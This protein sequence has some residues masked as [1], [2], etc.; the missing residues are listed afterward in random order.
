MKRYILLSLAIAILCAI[1]S[2]A[3]ITSPYPSFS[4]PSY[5]DPDYRVPGYAEVWYGRKTTLGMILDHCDHRQSVQDSSSDQQFRELSA[6]KEPDAYLAYQRGAKLFNERDYAQALEV[7][8]QLK[9]AP[10]PERGWWEKFFDRKSHSWVKEAS[11]YMVARCQLVMAQKNWSGYRGS[12]RLI[13]RNMV[14]SA[15]SSYRQYLDEYPDGIYANSARNIFR[16]IYVLLGK[17]MYLDQALREAVLEQY[18]ISTNYSPDKPVNKDIIQE[19][20]RYFRGKV[21]F[22]HDSPILCAYAW[23]GPD[24]PDPGDMTELEG[25]KKDFVVY[26]GLFRYVRALGLY[27]L[28]RYRE[29]LDKTPDEPIADTVMW[30]S[31]QILRARAFARLGDET[32][33][34]NLLEK[35]LD[36]SHE[37]EVE[38]EIADQ[39]LNR[40]DGLWLFTD[41]SPIESERNLR[42]FALYGLTDKELEFGI[43]MSEIDGK[44]QRFLA[45]ELARRYIL[46]GRFKELARLFAKDLV[47]VFFPIKLAAESLAANPR[48]VE[49]LADVGEFLYEKDINP[50][51]LLG[52]FGN[53]H[54]TGDPREDL[55]RCK[56]CQDFGERTKSYTP[57]ISFF[58]SVVEISKSTNMKSEAEAKALHYIVLGGKHGKSE[59]RCTWKYTYDDDTVLARSKKA[60]ER[61]H[62]LYPDS[63]WTKATPYYYK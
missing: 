5:I 35:M 7:F 38:V 61:L 30:L 1:S 58:Q 51:V 43:D 41:K 12:T 24:K 19:F 55:P 8:A 4:M 20:M 57:P 28:E 22:A 50:R 18:P 39:A 62:K 10:E 14:V 9:N 53:S 17:Q 52:N 25:R 11:S 21:D 49:A 29:L 44:K 32:S 26:P 13:N 23:L 16:K 34:M 60:F 2:H 6:Q 40:G 3:C 46:S 56:P 33:S 37:D 31:T 59:R 42:L 27:K 45:D 48:N 36:I 54:W 15:D 63:P 47:F